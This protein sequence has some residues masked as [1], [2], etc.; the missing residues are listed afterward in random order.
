MQRKIRRTDRAISETEAREVLRKAEYGVLSTV[1]KD[2]QPYGVPVSYSYAGDVIYF[3]SALEG[4]KLDNLQGNSRVSFCVVGK[5]EILP[6]KFAVKYESAIIFGT[7]SEATGDEKH[8][9]LLE[10]LRKYSPGFVEKGLQY[11]KKAGGNARV[12]KIVIESIT[13]KARK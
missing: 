8:K 13:G 3:H 1:S 11:L 5:T 12:Y 10:L 7:A 9:G 6:D 2:G 4:H